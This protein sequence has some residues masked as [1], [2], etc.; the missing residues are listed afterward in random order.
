MSKKIISVSID[1][2]SDTTKAAYSYANDKGEYVHGLLF[3]KGKGIPSMA[4]Y[5]TEKCTWVFGKKEILSHAQASFRYLVKVK[6]LLDLFFTRDASGKGFYDKKFFKN[7]YYPPKESESY[8]DAVENG[9]CF[10]ANTTAREVCALFVKY[11]VEKV[12]EEIKEIFG[13]VDIRYVV[14][15]PANAPKEYIAELVEFV[16]KA[17]K[18]DKDVWI[19]SAPRAVGLSA[20]EFGVVTKPTTA[21]LFNIGEED[22]SVVKIRFD[23]S[24][25]CVFSA[26]GHSSPAKVGGKDFDLALASH[27]FERSDKI[28]SF[29]GN[30]EGGEAEKGVFFD[31]FRMQEGIKAGKKNFSDGEAYARLGGFVFSI[32]REM[33]TSIKLVQEDFTE[34]CQPIFK[35][36]W[37]YV[38]NELKTGDND[39]VDELIFSGGAADTFGLDKY[40]AAKLSDNFPEIK[41][42]DFSPENESQGYDDILCEAKDTVPIGAAL[43]GAGKYEFKLLTTFAYGTYKGCTKNGRDGVAFLEFVPKSEEI[44]LEGRLDFKVVKMADDPLRPTIKYKNGKWMLFNE[45]YKVNTPSK[46]NYKTPDHLVFFDSYKPKTAFLKGSEARNIDFSATCYMGSSTKKIQCTRIGCYLMVFTF[47]S[48]YSG[49]PENDAQFIRFKEGFEID[50]EGR[51]TPIVLNF[52]QQ[53]LE[54]RKIPIDKS[55]R[56]YLDVKITLEPNGTESLLI[57]D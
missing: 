10:E 9:R 41:F 31:Q 29:G 47:P 20:K 36:V 18:M 7:F 54:K 56:T 22:I 45:Y 37:E 5:D 24:N 46:F 12:E 38:D 32:Y 48:Y 33:I 3:K 26:D 35:K 55:M 11:C 57:S 23:K 19:I 43:Y 53:Y 1:I 13:S 30:G 28:D 25:I 2:G 50:F 34:C 14:V 27:L 16:S 6:D 39:D 44:D 21:L 4:Y 42:L 17:A 40:I 51:V 8:A 15:Y 52:T 49:N